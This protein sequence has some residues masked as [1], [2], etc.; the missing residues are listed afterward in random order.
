MN[1]SEMLPE[2]AVLLDIDGRDKWQVIEALA[3]CLVTSGQVLEESTGAVLDGL[4]NRERS[5]TTGMENG[6]AIPHTSVDCVESTIAALGI[7]SSGVDFE[8][9]DGKTSHLIFMLVNPAGEANTHIRRLAEIARL[10]SDPGLRE[11]LVN[12]GTASDVLET[13]RSAEAATS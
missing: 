7:S 6:L 1:L 2:S 3:Q 13:I 11:S 5:M 9:I 4:L 10:L 12:C 8:A